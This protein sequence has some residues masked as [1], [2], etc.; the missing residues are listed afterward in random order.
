MIG[1]IRLSQPSQKGG[2]ELWHV[3][4]NH[5]W[6][7]S[8]AQRSAVTWKPYN[9]V[10]RLLPVS[11]GAR[12]WSCSVPMVPL[13]PTW[14]AGSGWHRAWSQ[15]GL[16]ATAHRGSAAWE[17]QHARGVPRAFP[18]EVAVHLVKVACER[19]ELCGRSLSPWDGTE[20]ARALVDS[21][22]TDSLSPSTVRRI[23]AHHKLNPWRPHRW[24]SPQH[25]RDAACYAP[26][27]ALITLSTR[28]LQPHEMVLSLEETTAL[29]PR[30]RLSPTKPAQPGVPNRV[31]HAYRRDGALHLFAAF[32]TRTGRVDGQGH[33]RQRPRECIAF[34][35]ALDTAIPS[36]ITTIH[37]VCANV[38][39]HPGKEGC[40]WLQSHPRFVCHFTPVPCS[41]MHQVEQWFSMLQRKRFGIVDV[42][43]QAVLQTPIEQFIAAWN[44]VA[45]PFNGSTKSVAKIMADASAKAA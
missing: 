25:P 37:V 10:Q 7:S 20:L 13:W 43:S 31:E 39:T 27:T 5:R 30:P 24:L 21:G 12:A 23:L 45:H 28:P 29:Q 8:S 33:R 11:H 42:A 16:N 18:P 34:L 38:S 14:P 15:S 17:I 4:A 6:S 40:P 3:A 9:G 26:V 41:W 19:P 32:D 2:I 35:S 44:Q 36:T 22:G 1:P